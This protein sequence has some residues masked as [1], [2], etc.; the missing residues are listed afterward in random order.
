[1]VVMEWDAVVTVVWYVG[2]REN[3]IELSRIMIIGRRNDS[4]ARFF[5]WKTTTTYVA[6][7][8]YATDRYIHELAR[9]DDDFFSRVPYL[10]MGY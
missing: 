2:G 9:I 3:V 6:M 8:T 5:M 1:M 4:P 10:N 7:L